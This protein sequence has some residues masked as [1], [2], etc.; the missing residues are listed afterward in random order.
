MTGPDLPGSALP[1][2]QIADGGADRMVIPLA[3]EVEPVTGVPGNGFK[4]FTQGLILGRQVD[5][6]VCGCVLRHGRLNRN[7]AVAKEAGKKRFSWWS[8]SIRGCRPGP[9][10]GILKLDIVIYLSFDFWIL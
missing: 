6:R 9:Q 5:Q 2:T 10:I 3:V 1:N 4:D 8:S 7:T